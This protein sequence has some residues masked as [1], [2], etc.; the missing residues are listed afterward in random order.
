ASRQCRNNTRRTYRK[1]CLFLSDFV[2]SKITSRKNYKTIIDTVYMIELAIVSFLAGLGLFFVCLQ[3]L[4][5][6]LKIVTGKK[7]RKLIVHFTKSAAQGVILGGILISVTQSLSAMVFTLIGMARAKA[8][9]IKQALPIIIGGNIFGGVV[10]FL[11]S[12]D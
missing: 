4:S 10:L 8:I 12:F 7:V 11:I 3:T 2:R 1:R 6:F 5:D 9:E